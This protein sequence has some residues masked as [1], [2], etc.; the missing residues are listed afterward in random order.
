MQVKKQTT[1]M[2]RTEK[3]LDYNLNGFYSQNIKIRGATYIVYVEAIGIKNKNDIIFIEETSISQIAIGSRYGD[4]LYN[5]KE[6]LI[7]STFSK[8]KARLILELYD[9][10]KEYIQT[11]T[12]E[13]VETVYKKM[14]DELVKKWIL[15][16]LLNM[17]RNNP[18]DYDEHY[19]EINGFCEILAIETK[20]FL[21]NLFVLK[22]DGHINLGA[23]KEYTTQNGGF[24]IT[25]TGI[26]QYEQFEKQ[27]NLIS[28]N[29]KSEIVSDLKRNKNYTDEKYDI[30]I[31]FA[32]EDRAI[33]EDLAI[34]FKE[35]NISVF[36]DFYEE[37]TLWGKDLYEYLSYI[38]SESAKYC[39]MIISANYEK[40]LWTNHERKS[41]QARAFREKSEY[42]LPI[43][44][45]DT[46]I[47]GLHETVGYIKYNNNPEKIVDLTIMKLNQNN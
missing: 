9:K 38:Y 42:I 25:S 4:M 35:K 41:A 5:P 13:N 11:I 14:P 26:K 1:I 44:V 22:E 24:Y 29:I 39:L 20:Q 17:R 19:F 2:D 7:E 43:K 15:K 31:S 6:E 23:T 27:S 33:A 21:F 46:K 34:R 40:K 32:G 30:V 28:N 8:A 37:A 10:G 12:T 18:M 16:G 3:Y 36:Y 45:D 47:P